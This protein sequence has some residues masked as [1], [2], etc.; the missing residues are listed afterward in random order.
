M[1]VCISCG[2][3]FESP[4]WECP[5]CNYS[6]PETNGFPVFSPETEEKFKGFDTGDFEILYKFEA[7]NFWFRNRNKIIILALKKYFPE[8]KSFLEIG[9]GTGFVLSGIEKSFPSLALSGSDIFREGLSYASRRV[10]KACLLQM[11]ARDIP[12]KEEFDVI[13]AFDVLEHI[14][15]DELALSQIYKAVKQGGGII[16]TVPQHK[17]LWSYAD[18]YA[19]H[20]RRYESS[21]LKRKVEDAGFEVI[22]SSSFV[23]LLLPLMFISRK[24][25][26]N[27]GKHDPLS[28]LKTG[29]FTG[30]VLERIL[31]LERALI[32]SGIKF[33]YGG[34]LLIIGRKKQT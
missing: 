12:F 9:C 20:V 25:K 10:E 13:G 3:E 1:K 32:R 34:S 23:S 31:D 33:P 29:G 28:E 30:F 5:S 17:F 24:M 7:G 14:D 11:D 19:C 18:E 6:P 4:G 8:T 16:I 15:E 2:T 26:K 27:P 21:E 22:H